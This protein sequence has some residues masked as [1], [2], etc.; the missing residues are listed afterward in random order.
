MS[1]DKSGSGQGK[2]NGKT[3]ALVLGSGG[4]RGY[5]HVG[6]IEVLE[7]RG[8]DIVALSGCS[9]GALVGGIY[10]AGKLSE[11]KDWA[12][13]LDRFD[14]LRLLDVS[15]SSPGAIR[16]EKVFSIVRDLIG[17]TKIED[18]SI[19]YTAVATDLLHHKE[20]WFQE[21]L[22]RQAIRASVAIP[23]LLT[24]EVIKGRVLVDGGLLNP[25]PIIPTIAS[26]ADL[27][28]AA[29]LSF[30]DAKID[31]RYY[32]TADVRS[33]RSFE[34]WMGQVWQKAAQIFD[35]DAKDKLSEVLQLQETEDPGKA[36]SEKEKSANESKTSEESKQA[37]NVDKGES[38][39]ERVLTLGK[40]DAMNM[41]FEAMQSS[42][43]QYKLAGYPPDI[44]VNIP[45]HVCL[46]FDYHKAPELIQIGREITTK[47]LD[48]FENGNGSPYRQL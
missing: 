4:A 6:V 5:A 40:F 1:V 11:F 47:T 20:I 2:K 26:H 7:E 35:R 37:G 23:S 43:T 30:Y 10:A 19:D 31:E 24:P 32:D 13:G 9:M 12:T 33:D 16:G 48:D 38:R 3:V 44:L 36:A 17:D 18:L 34:D 45:K 28:V 29:N 15:F 39:K 41:A 22:L 8:Y 25:L 21:G 14:I 27:I 42:L 46:S